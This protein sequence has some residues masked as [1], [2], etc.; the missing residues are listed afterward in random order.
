MSRQKKHLNSIKVS[1]EKHTA[2]SASEKMP[3]PE[4]VSI[5]MAQHIGAPCKPLVSKGDHIKL[6]QP[7]GDSDAFVS[8]DTLECIRYCERYHYHEICYGWRRSD[9]RC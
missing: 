4:T 3:L 1:H 9:D 5:S 7:V 2:A 6:G 8:A